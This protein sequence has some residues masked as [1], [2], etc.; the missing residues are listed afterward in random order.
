VLN[1]EQIL[2]LIPHR[3]PF[4]WIDSIVELEIGVRCVALKSIDPSEALFAGHFPGNAILPGVI[5]IEAAAQTAAVM[6]SSAT[7]HAAS[8]E[9]STAAGGSRLLAAVNRFKFLKPVR[10]GSELRIET[11]VVTEVGPMAYV[12]ATVWVGHD[13]VAKGEL[14]VVSS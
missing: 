5:I 13:Q 7:R 4:L 2:D 11:T 14:A 10:P 6:L 8:T 1:R 9:R 3:P 12:E